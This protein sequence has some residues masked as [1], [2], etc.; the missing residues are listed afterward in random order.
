LLL[1]SYRCLE[2]NMKLLKSTRAAGLSHRLWLFDFIDHDAVRLYI[3]LYAS[4]DGCKTLIVD[5][6]FIE[7]NADQ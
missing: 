4:L 2:W 7:L 5:Q 6:S 1:R 3:I